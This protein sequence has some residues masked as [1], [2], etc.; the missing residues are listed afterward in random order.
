[1]RFTYHI[2]LHCTDRDRALGC[3]LRNGA[4]LA[5]RGTAIAAPERFRPALREAMLALKGTP[6]PAEMQERLMDAVTDLDAPEHV[7]FSSDSFL[8]VPARAV[9]GGTLYPLVSER[10]PWI[11]NLFPDS[12]AHFC[13]ALCNP[14]T[15]LPALQSRFAESESFDDFLARTTP[16]A[17]S[18]ADMVARLRAA[19]PDAEITLWCNEDAPLLWP[20]ILALLAG[21]PEDPSL[22]DGLDGAGDFLAELMHPEGTTRLGTYLEQNA[23]R[24]ASHRRRIIAAFLDRFA[25]PEAVSETYDLPG[26]TEE[27]V[28]R[29]TERYEADIARIDRMEGVRLLRP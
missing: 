26:W 3:L 28:A 19:V 27:R 25:R 22:P 1:M 13:L 20:E 14:A 17:L 11:R 6:A 7:M 5:A 4:A 15:L 8:C 23:P 12:P 16:E 21:A 9:S 24:S 18:W 29:L 10:A 2:G